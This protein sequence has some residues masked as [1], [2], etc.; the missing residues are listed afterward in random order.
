MD[1]TSVDAV[2]SSPYA[3][4][5]PERLRVAPVSPMDDFND[6]SGDRREPWQASLDRLEDL[7][8]RL[9]VSDDLEHDEVARRLMA[10]VELDRTTSFIVLLRR[11]GV[12][13]DVNPGAL[14]AGG[15]DRTEVV[16]S[17]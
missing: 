8:R 10:E 13:L 4:D 11:D 6:R 3:G 1:G 7:R 12:V 15:L 14:L 16:G 5:V 17:L 9:E 2:G